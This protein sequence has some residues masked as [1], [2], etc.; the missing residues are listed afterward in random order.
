M[1]FQLG[2]IKMEDGKII[3]NKTRKY[4]API[5]K[6]YGDI[7]TGKFNSVFKV[8]CGIGDMAVQNSGINYERHLFILMD[9]SIGTRHFLSFLDWVKEQDYYEDDYVY[10]NI[11]KSNLHMIVLKVPEQFY[12]SLETFRQGKYSKMY[13][14]Q[15][16]QTYF[17]N[18]PDVMKVLIKDSN[19]KVEF[20]GEVNKLFGTEIDNF[21]IKDYELDFPLNPMEETFM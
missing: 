7:F 15:S 1:K 3:Q 18:N 20:I 10:G 6:C 8:A 19:Y 12:D 11:L 4:L 5:L 16:I 2:K 17:D 14:Y 21:D 13:D 9:A